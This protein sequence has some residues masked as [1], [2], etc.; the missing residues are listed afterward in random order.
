M[1]G[2]DISIVSEDK[3]INVYIK[4]GEN[5]WPLDLSSGM[6]K[7]VSSLAI[8]VGLINVSNLPHPNFLVIDEGFGT[9]DSD[10]LSNM[11][12]AFDYLKTRFDSVFII[13]HLDTIK[14][15]MDYLLP[16]NKNK[17]YSSVKY[18]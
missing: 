18:M 17:D 1:A 5:Q 9:L 12:G 8:R 3:N 15:F 6:E 2:F 14:D 10:N 16:I 11:K 13:S 4:Y 7:F